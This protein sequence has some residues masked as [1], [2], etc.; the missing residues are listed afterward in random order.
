MRIKKDLAICIGVSA[1]L[2][3][4]T[5]VGGLVWHNKAMKK[6]EAALTKQIDINAQR[7]A[8]ASRSVY[9][10]VSDIKKG[11]IID[12][13]L[14]ETVS[15]CISDES[16][17]VFLTSDDIGKE[18]TINITAGQFLTKN[19]VTNPL[20]QNWHE[21]ELDCINLSS[22]LKQYDYVDVRILLPNGLD[23]LVASKK[24]VR[25]I[26]LETN[27]VFLWLNEE[28]ILLIDSAL[29]DANINGGRLY[30]TRYAKPAIQ[31]AHKVT[32]SPTSQIIELAK[33][34]KNVEKA[35]SALSKTA[36]RRM[37]EKLEE[38]KSNYV[39]QRDKDSLRGYSFDLDT[40]G[41]ASKNEHVKENT[42]DTT[43][44]DT[45]STD[46]GSTDTDTVDAT[47]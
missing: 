27:D 31:K 40:K 9:R 17:D 33:I 37:E 3:V 46:T 22:N 30:T 8:S 26:D 1:V 21:T 5:I 24:C 7:L 38:F 10:A 12:D 39:D 16:Q 11:T 19:M 29:V 34:D 13:S 6:Q 28:E 42:E 45:G 14:I 35:K 18:A 43:G 25:Q 20:T 15:D 32:Y 4:G 36:R 44:T 41:G 47:E 2:L 23:Y